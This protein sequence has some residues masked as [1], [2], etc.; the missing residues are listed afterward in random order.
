MARKE[1][2]IESVKGSKDFG[3]YKIVELKRISFLFFSFMYKKTLTE[4]T[5]KYIEAKNLASL[6]VH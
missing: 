6:Y 3:V 4:F 5:G 2:K 1:I